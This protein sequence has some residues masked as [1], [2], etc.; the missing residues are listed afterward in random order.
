ME[1]GKG[2]SE[3][4]VL[5]LFDGM[6]CGQV[7]LKR[8]GI[9]VHIYFASEVDK[10][11]I[12]VANH[13]HNKTIQLGDVQNWRNW[14]INWS[15]ID[16]LLGG[17]PCQGF[18]SAGKEAA[19]NDPRS[20]LFFTYAEILQHIKSLNPKVKFLLEN[21]KMKKEFLNVITTFVGVEPVM[22]NSALVSAQNRKR[23]YWANWEFSQPYDRNIQMKDI[24]EEFFIDEKLYMKDKSNTIRVGGR[25]SPPL[26]K[27]NWDCVYEN[28]IRIG[29]AS[30]LKGHDYVK[31]IYDVNGKS[32]TLCA[33]SGGNLEP[34]IHV[35]NAKIVGRKLDNN[36][37]RK[38]NDPEIPLTQYLQVRKNEKSGCLTTVQKDN[39]ISILSPG[40]YNMNN[41]HII[42]FYRKLT[43]TE[44]ER[45]QTL[46]DGYTDQVSKSQ[47]YK[48]LGNGWNVDTIVHILKYM[49][50]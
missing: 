5:S 40:D 27:H 15:K 4:Q 46:P 19:F 10:Y 11:A 28:P 21:V 50:N 2:M 25:G 38:D 14:P 48:M 23:Y 49:N 45:L 9:P 8:A 17:S 42:N 30:D 39:V 34:K 24:I 6:S 3:L 1:S 32:P 33:S 7:A 36:G 31:R 35:N 47:A 41:D 12:K 44:C 13:N 18:S 20:K 26:D 29:T 16:L 22:I 37:V 43:V